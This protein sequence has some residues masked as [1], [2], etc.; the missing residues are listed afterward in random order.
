MFIYMN[1]VLFC[2]VLFCTSSSLK[3]YNKGVHHL[4]VSFFFKGLHCK[5]ANFI[6]HWR[7]ILPVSLRENSKIT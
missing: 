1:K 4:P 3:K 6:L 7:K 5:S 2:S